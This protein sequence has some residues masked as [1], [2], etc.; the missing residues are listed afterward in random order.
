M[1]LR[2][3]DEVKPCPTCKKPSQQILLPSEGRGEFT[4]PVVIHVD[5]KGNY[6]FP[7]SPD[8]KLPPGF[9]KRELKTIRDIEHF[10]HQ[11]NAKLRSDSDR[12]HEN[13]TQAFAQIQSR[14]RSELRT[15]MQRMSPLGRDFAEMAMKMNDE[16]KRKSND[17][18]FHV[19]ILHFNQSNREAQRD[20]STDWKRR[21]S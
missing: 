14:L 3:W 17:C 6:R 13:E 20:A 7:G 19:E 4:V 1:P 8:A 5:A 12:H 10:E 15:A 21:H 2:R 11:M 16:R 18:G 9:E